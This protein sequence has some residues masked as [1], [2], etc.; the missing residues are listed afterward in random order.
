M[1]ES[2]SSQP[3]LKDFIRHLDNLEWNG[4]SL[5]DLHKMRGILSGDVLDKDGEV[6]DTLGQEEGGVWENV[7]EHGA[8]SMIVADVLG[9]AF[10]LSREERGFLNLAVWLQDSG[11]KT[12]RM[13][14]SVLEKK[15]GASEEK[16][17]ASE[18]QQIM[19]RNV[20]EMEEWENAEAGLFSPRMTYL[21]RANVPETA[22][23]HGDDLAAKISWFADAILNG[24]EIVGITKR[25]RDLETDTRNGQ[26]NI[27]FSDSFKG[28]YGGKSLYTVQRE[29]G[30]QYE[31]EFAQRLEIGKDE[32]YPWLRK[33]VNERILLQRMPV[34]PPT[35][36]RAA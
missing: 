3:T 8:V 5:T 18:E 21:M 25:F 1:S 27:A 28:K 26:W 13:W 32:L 36:Q 12:E 2:L 19:L 10:G 16:E 11:K 29:L 35:P 15:T 14:Q 31:E 4:R 20:S 24:A 23:G 17:N 34:M 22:E 7:A 33:K 6:Y 30:A 9:E